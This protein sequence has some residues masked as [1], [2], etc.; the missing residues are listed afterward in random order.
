MNKSLAFSIITEICGHLYLALKH[1]H[2]PERKI[3]FTTAASHFLLPA[4]GSHHSTFCLTDFS[5]LGISYKWNH[6]ISTI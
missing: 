4:V 5:S 2:H 6:I 3:A 1:F